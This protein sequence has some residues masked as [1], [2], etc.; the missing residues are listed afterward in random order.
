VAGEPAALADVQAAVMK[1]AAAKAPTQGA[2]SATQAD[3]VR[4]DL[5]VMADQAKGYTQGVNA[6]TIMAQDQRAAQGRRLAIEAQEA[7]AARARE[8]QAAK[9]RQQQQRLAMDQRK[10]DMDFR[11]QAAT[12]QGQAEEQEP[13]LANSNKVLLHLKSNESQNLQ[14]AFDAFV[15]G[16]GATNAAEAMA[17]FRNTIEQDDASPYK[18]VGPITLQRYATAY[19]RALE[20][21]AVSSLLNKASNRGGSPSRGSSATTSGGSSST[22]SP[23]SSGGGDSLVDRFI[24]NP[25]KSLRGL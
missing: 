8:E 3:A 24:N 6:G 18:H 11:R 19:F 1:S 7:A 23:K 15:L 4:Q 25:L 17:I 21:K 13:D 20:G 22:S 5:S 12:V 14:E 10:Q 9:I 16:S 2:P